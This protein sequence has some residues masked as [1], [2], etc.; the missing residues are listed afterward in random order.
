[1][2]LCAILILIF[3]GELANARQQVKISTA[4]INHF[5]EAYD[6]L[7]TT[8]DSIG[9]LQRLYIDRAS[10]GLKEFIK[11][12]NFEAGEYVTLI[13]NFPKF[14]TSIRSN[15]ERIVTRTK[16]IETIFQKF[17][18]IFPAFRPP[19]V[20]FA[21]GCLRTGG[22]TRSDLIMIGSEIASA[23]STTNAT[24]F[25]GWLTYVLSSSSDI[26]AMVA[27]E[28]VHTQQKNNLGYAKGYFNQ[29]LLT[30]S[31]REGGADFIGSLLTGSIIN[32]V[33]YEYGIAHEAEL[34]K[35]FQQHMNEKDFSRWLYNGDKSLDRPADLGYFI[36]YRI[37]E[38]YYNQSKDKA[39][40][41]RELLSIKNYPK[42]L[43]KSGYGL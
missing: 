20:C 35:E 12:R 15:T 39:K 31:I 28:A 34:W 25:R 38:R 6:S 4:D 36:G 22:T 21:I 32:K 40:A 3:V 24:E 29:R 19:D 5:W 18:E 33:Q 26:T 2:R 11:A 16:E 43:K 1:M 37:C 41:I 10:W 23:D 27:H 8:R 42:F 30:Q 9:T 14:W 17:K 7:A 13:K